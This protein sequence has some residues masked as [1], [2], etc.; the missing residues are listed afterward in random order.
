M[1]RIGE[2]VRFGTNETWLYLI[3]CREEL[4]GSD[5]IQLTR[6]MLAHKLN[7]RLSKCFRKAN[8][9]LKEPR[10]GLVHTHRS[11][12]AQRGKAVL[13]VN[14]LLVEGVTVLMQH[15]IDIGEHV[16][17]VSMAGNHDKANTRATGVR[18]LSFAKPIS[19]LVKTLELYQVFCKIP[20]TVNVKLTLKRFGAWL[21]LRSH[22]IS[23]QRNYHFFN[24][25]E[26]GVVEL[27]VGA[28]LKIA[29]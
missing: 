15:G 20:L 1:Q 11:A 13:P 6:E 23:N 19:V 9:V 7:E 17:L 25:I 12:G 24:I 27:S 16:I 18:V 2:L 5:A 28:V 14:A 3:S 8:V 22:T 10:L 4:E 21:T 26:E 29:E